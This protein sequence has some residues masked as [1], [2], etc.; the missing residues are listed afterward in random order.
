M[1][2]SPFRPKIPFNI[3]LLILNSNLIKNL[4]EVKSKDVYEQNSTVFKQDGLFSTE[5]F[6]P[7]GSPERMTKFGYINMGIK[8]LHPLIYRHLT[9]LETLYKGILTGDKYAVWDENI[10]NF[11]PADMETGQTGYN[12]FMKYYDKIK[13]RETN[14]EKRTEIIKFIKKYKAKDVLIDKY[15]VIPAGMRDRMELPNGKVL[16]DEINNLYRK[17]LTVS[18]TAKKLQDDMR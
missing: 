15:L 1:S 7:K 2:D 12:F 11:V 5:I 3:E 13:F 6:G 10:L 17:L 18:S 14:S 16:E 4:G 8:I 9:K